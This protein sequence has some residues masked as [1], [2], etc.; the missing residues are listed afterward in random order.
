MLR[1]ESQILGHAYFSTDLTEV[2]KPIRVKHRLQFSKEFPNLLSVEFLI[3][4]GASTTISVF[5]RD[6]VIIFDYEIGNTI[7]N[8]LHLFDPGP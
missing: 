8:R 4:V 1:I 3:Q 7:C 5:S 6:G 2:Q